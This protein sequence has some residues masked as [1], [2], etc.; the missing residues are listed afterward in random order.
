[1]VPFD[2]EGDDAKHAGSPLKAFHFSCLQ[3]PTRIYRVVDKSLRDAFYRLVADDPAWHRG[4]FHHHD[5]DG[6]AM[7]GEPK[8]PFRAHW[9]TGSRA[10]RYIF[11]HPV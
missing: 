7:F 8:Y 9:N 1:M 10:R 4:A 6:D 11:H 5:L 2:V 3:L